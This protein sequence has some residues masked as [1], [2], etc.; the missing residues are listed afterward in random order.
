MK[1]D[2]AVVMSGGGMSGILLELGFLRRLRESPLWP[3][4]TLMVGTSAGALA[5]CAAALDRLDDL[6]SFLLRLR[7]ED[8]F[9]P[10]R[11]WRLPLLGTHDYV[12]PRTVAAGLGEPV[13]LAR[14]LVSSPVELV[15]VVTDVTAH[16]SPQ[17]SRRLFER[18]YSSR[19]APPEEMAEAVF[20]SAAISM[21]VVPQL[22]GDTV[23][24]DGGWVRNY[25]LG[26][27]YERADVALIVGFKYE[28][29]FPVLGLRPLQTAARRLRHVLRLPA[30]RSIARELDEAAAREQRGQP[31]HV[32]DTLSRLSRVST[33]RNTVLEELVADWREQSVREL[34]SLRQDVD[35]LLG[36]AP[37]DPDERA[38]LRDEVD[39]RFDRAR[40]PFRHDRVT[41]R[42]T[43]SGSSEPYNLEPALRGR[44][45]WSIE[46]KRALIDRGY[47]LTEA[48]LRTH[49]IG[50]EQERAR[51]QPSHTFLTRRSTAP[52]RGEPY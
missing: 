31:A 42:I 6:E 3:R 46:A 30:A 45:S 1:R 2:V 24:T 50:D 41:P 32:V 9:H 17:G 14:E 36:S 16:S 23:A 43:V 40:F 7:P 35:D 22:V 47:A 5:G 20:A 28:M 51:Q 13:E 29:E 52:H 25:P 10:H 4:V 19:T 38:R 21:L 8:T 15:V 18:S 26:Y 12:L 27:A 44:R 39:R 37:I 48:E 34:G 49:G 11:L 33:I